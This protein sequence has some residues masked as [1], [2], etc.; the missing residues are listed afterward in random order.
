MAYHMQ[1]QQ[2][3]CDNNEGFNGD[4][5]RVRELNRASMKERGWAVAASMVWELGHRRHFNNGTERGRDKE[6]VQ[7]EAK[8]WVRLYERGCELRIKTKICHIQRWFW[9]TV[10]EYSISMTC[11]LKSVV[12]L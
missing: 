4:R 1:Q 8:D 6:K 12:D 9:K 5:V 7:R 11:L 3:P 10:F 2:C